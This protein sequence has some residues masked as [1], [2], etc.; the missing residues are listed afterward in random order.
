VS[1]AEVLPDQHQRDRIE[2]ELDTTMLV[3]AAAGTGK[4][5]SMIDRMVALLEQGTCTIDTLAAVTFTRKAAAEMRS[6]FQAELESRARE[7]DGERARRLADAAEEAGRCFIGT[8]HSFCG[9]LLRERPVEAG[10]SPGFEQLEPEED[11]R[12]RREA[13]QEFCERLYAREDPRIE[14]LA[15]MGMHL[16]ELEDA[17][18]E[19]ASFPDV[20]EW[21]GEP[22][23]ELPEVEEALDRELERVTADAV[24][25]EEVDK[26]IKQ[27]K[28]QFA[29]SSES[30]TGQALW[31]G[32]S[33][34]FA[35]RTWADR[36]LENLSAVTVERVRRAAE[37]YLHPSN[38]TVGWY[39]P[40]SDD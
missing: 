10:V 13:W 30:V 19:R 8:I 34:V 3:E 24:T 2:T 1:D 33:E 18:D 31:L 23:M 29:Y 4:T 7:A 15:D 16:S 27:A 6:R 37:K 22:E 36:Y 14:K 40:T 9:R 25:Q 38:R 17:F 5:T 26:A 20:Q 11:E 21:P 32:F 35:D 28:A 12:L 39:L